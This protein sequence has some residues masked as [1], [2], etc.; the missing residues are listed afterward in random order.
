MVCLNCTF[1][2]LVMGLNELGLGLGSC[3]VL[4]SV[5]V[6]KTANRNGAVALQT[7]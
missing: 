6:G 7:M 5:Q 3:V 1:S 2:L 4:M